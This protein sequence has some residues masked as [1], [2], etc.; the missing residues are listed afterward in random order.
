MIDPAE[1]ELGVR[2]IEADSG[3]NAKPG[4]GRTTRDANRNTMIVRE[5]DSF[6]GATSDI[7]RL[8]CGWI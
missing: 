7:A 4:I 8:S 1:P 6:K 5:R 3:E 2:E